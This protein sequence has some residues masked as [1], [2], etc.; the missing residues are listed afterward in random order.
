[1][2]WV[3]LDQALWIAGFLPLFS[4][5]SAVWAR[6]FF[7]MRKGIHRE[8][9][10]ESKSARTISAGQAAGATLAATIGTGNIVGTAQA[11]AMGGPGAVF[12]MWAAAL[13][14][15]PVKAAEILMGQRMGGAMGYIRR[16]L[17]AIPARVYSLLALCNVL[18]LGNMAQMNTAASLSKGAE[19]SGIPVSRL[20]SSILLIALISLCLKKGIGG[21]ST[22]CVKIVFVMAGLYLTAGA[23]A[24][25]LH[26]GQILPAFRLILLCAM[27]P[28]AIFGAAAGLLARRACLWGL[29][30]GGFSNEAGLGTAANIHA[31]TTEA[32][33]LRNVLWGVVEVF[34]DTVLCTISALVILTASVPIFYG[35]MPGS[36]L[37]L[38]ALSGSFGERY[39]L[40]LLMLC[41]GSFALST[42]MGTYISGLRCADS[43]G[44]EERRYH[45]L[46]LFC[47]GLGSVLPLHWIWRA[48]DGVNVL[49]ALPNLLALFLLG[50]QNEEEKGGFPEN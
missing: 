19:P 10:L 25:T 34:T 33:P 20:T 50:K 15:M 14:G 39:A 1:M 36:E 12:W 21:I 49:M 24:L 45:L 28:R 26:A 18:I 13:L 9:R 44:M 22:V 16:T 47:A 17:G 42:V 48:A 37:L 41:L 11:I 5:C 30:R 6:R 23:A 32:D 2:I 3:H 40:C 31:Y 38:R 7:S 46:F 27:Q 4:A 35:I 8:T 43:L 29:K